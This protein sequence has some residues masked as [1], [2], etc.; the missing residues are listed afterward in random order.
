VAVLVELRSG[1]HTLLERIRQRLIGTRP[2]RS[3]SD[4]IA[5]IG[6]QAGFR[7]FATSHFDN[8][9]K[10]LDLLVGDLTEAK[11][12]TMGRQEIGD[13]LNRTLFSIRLLLN[14]IDPSRLRP[15]P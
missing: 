2:G 8:I 15:K 14:S 10:Q 12:A 9:G 1:V 3:I 13:T 11:A 4:R 5:N 6:L 7:V